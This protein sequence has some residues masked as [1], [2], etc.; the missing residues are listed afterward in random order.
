MPKLTADLQLF[1]KTQKATFIKRLNRFVVECA[2]NDEV[3]R[4]YLPNPGRLRELLLPG[5]ILSLAENL[6][7][8]ERKYRYTAVAV[9]RDNIPVLLHTH[10]SNDV[11]RWLIEK[12]K[13]AGFGDAE[14]VK[15]E[16]TVGR[17]RFDFLLMREGN[18]FLL[19]VKS[20][21]LFGKTIA[22]FPDAVTERGKRH[23]IELAEQSR[24]G[25][26]A[27]VIFLVH[28]PH[29]RWFLPDYHTD[30]EFARTLYEVRNKIMV[31]ALFIGWHHD[32][33]LAPA[34]I[35]ELTIP[36]HIVEGEAKDSGSYILLL[37]LTKDARIEVGK[38]GS[39]LFQ[40]GWYLY[41]GSAKRNLKKRVARHMRRRKNPF[42]HIDYLREEADTCI[43]IPVRS[44]TP[45]QCPMAKRLGEIADWSVL[46][47]G[48]SDC[49][50]DTHLF[51][52]HAHPLEN[53]LFIEMIQHFRIDRLEALLS[54]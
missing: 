44:S 7:T 13:V 24:K 43:P 12:G 52:M 36:W 25:T 45:L 42:W 21:T 27:G 26:Q 32:L 9:E 20:C 34:A 48:S 37:H 38:L 40:K 41:A 54:S 51:G 1:A 39:M 33:T 14:V 50:C 23:L 5:R 35:G 3:I 16:A 28:W 18:P 29:A 19:E 46:K 49:H 15:P 4:A 30:I 8:P 53:F 22:M 47:F 17:S 31:K 10:R 2:V 11:V 6:E